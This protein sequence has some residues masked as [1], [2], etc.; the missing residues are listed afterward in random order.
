MVAIGLAGVAGAAV[1]TQGS[2][3]ASGNP[4][5]CSEPLPMGSE[6][7][8]LDPSEF[9]PTIDNEYWPMAPGTRWTLVETDGKGST[10]KVHIEVKDRTK[11]IL[12]IAATIVRDTVSERGAVIED[13]RD[14]YAQDVCGNIWYLGENTK[15][16]EDGQVVSTE[17]S[18]QAGVD[19]AEAGV[20]LPGAPTV[21]LSYRQEYLAGEAEDAATVISLG[22]QVRVP[23]AH[24]KDVLVT[25]DYTS[26]A[27]R[28][29]EYKF[30]APGVGP[31][32]EIGLSGGSDR[33]VLT[34]FSPGS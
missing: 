20:A 25:K 7:A 5:P 9:V 22:D 13:T 2:A 6:P 10:S 21:G 26:L 14:W 1:L 17:G 12:G 18:W 31:V 32:E 8:N 27:P 23:F 29:L 16:Y 24:F 11:L 30:Y 19:G 15:E 34:Q 4:D 3:G 33:A 28:V